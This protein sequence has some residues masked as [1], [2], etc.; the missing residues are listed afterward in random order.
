MC[1]RMARIPSRAVTGQRTVPVRP[2][3]ISEPAPNWSHLDVLR[4]MRTMRGLAM[5]STATSPHERSVTG[6][7]WLAASGNNSPSRKKLKNAAQEIVHSTTLFGFEE[8]SR[9]PLM[10]PS[11][12]AVMGNR[13]MEGVPCSILERRM[14]ACTLLRI[15]RIVP[16]GQAGPER[17]ACF[18]RQTGTISQ[19]G[20]RD[21][22]Q[23]S[24]PK[25]SKV[26]AP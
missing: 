10:R 21:P 20:G 17:F 1:P 15:R 12:D 3:I 14:P 5:L 9:T 18:S 24:R 16:L 4:C 26:T 2:T 11:T 25:S 22:D 23:L 6:W 13:I 7:N 19:S 8:A